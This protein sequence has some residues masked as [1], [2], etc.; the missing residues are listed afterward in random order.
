MRTA[1]ISILTIGNELL[2]GR[3]HDKNGAFLAELLHSKGF[4]VS[5]ILS[6]SDDISDIH[7]SLSFLETQSEVIVC[8]G[9]LGPTSDDL[10]AQAVAE[11]FN[12]KLCFHE[13]AYEDIEK[14]LNE[15]GYDKI[16]PI[17]KKQAQIPATAE[18]LKNRCGTAPCF[19]VNRDHKDS[20]AIFVFPGVPSEF[21]AMVKEELLP[22]LVKSF[23]SVKA[24]RE[25]TLKLINLRESK[26]ATIIEALN[27]PK[28]LLISYRPSFPQV[29][30]KFSA[31]DD[32][33]DLESVKNGVR[34]AIGIEHVFT[35]NPAQDFTQSCHELFL[36]K[37]ITIAVAE[38]CT[39]GLLG[40]LLTSCPGSSKYFLGGFLTYSNELKTKLIGVPAELIDNYGAVSK[41]VA[42]AM[43]KGTRDKLEADYALSITGIAGP[44]GGSEDKPVG[45]FYVGIATPE[46]V[47]A[48]KHY[49]VA[50]R[51]R[52]RERASYNA[53]QQLRCYLFENR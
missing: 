53:L 18:Y 47:F 16:D 42:I 43:A 35:D 38:S 9:G 13:K 12:D 25:I 49:F 31:L 33:V 3:I 45:T 36:K 34:A 37:D 52:I 29:I 7:R 10:T 51:E 1:F 24:P 8:S 46:D 23:P 39:G 17:Y 2:D 5:H 15:R 26:A 44:E 48:T 6:C 28:E 14:M 20:A 40:K 4:K 50:G 27:L 32:S 30:I 21:Y 19:V 11:L 22:Y 41:E